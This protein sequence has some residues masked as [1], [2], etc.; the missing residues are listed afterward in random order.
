MLHHKPGVGLGVAVVA[1]VTVV[2]EVLG[3]TKTV[4]QVG[5]RVGLG[6]GVVGTVGLSVGTVGF[7]VGMVVLSVGTVGF[8]VGMV[9]FLVGMVVLSVGTVGF[10][11]GATGF[12][13]RMVDISV[14]TVGVSSGATRFSVQTGVSGGPVQVTGGLEGG[15]TDAGP[16][17][18]IN[19]WSLV[20]IVPPRP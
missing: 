10:S 20:R 18:K 3:I 5:T 19:P 17:K 1:G 12:S 2:M 4:G 8:S 16:A 14:G 11:M 13:V 6:W 9:V 15:A 7:S